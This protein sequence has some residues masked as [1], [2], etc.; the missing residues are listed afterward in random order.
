MAMWFSFI[1]YDE[2]LCGK[3]NATICKFQQQYKGTLHGD[4]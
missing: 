4:M 1:V 2:C 3:R